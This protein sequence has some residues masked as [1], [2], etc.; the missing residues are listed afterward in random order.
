MVKL[1]YVL[2]CEEMWNFSGDLM[3]AISSFYLNFITFSCL[4]K[5][6]ISMP[7]RQ[8]HKGLAEENRMLLCCLVLQLCASVMSWVDCLLTD[9]ELFILFADKSQILLKISVIPILLAFIY[10]VAL[11]LFVNNQLN[12]SLRQKLGRS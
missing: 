7:D 5:H 12:S 1:T 9:S 4:E 8:T 2:F 10:L 11:N 6:L 3:Y